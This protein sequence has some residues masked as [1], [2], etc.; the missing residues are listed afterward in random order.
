MPP[1]FLI[2][3]VQPGDVY[4]RPQQDFIPARHSSQTMT[5]CTCWKCGMHQ[6]LLS[7]PAMDL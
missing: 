7:V 6:P 5:G 3:L 2:T 1:I 4:F